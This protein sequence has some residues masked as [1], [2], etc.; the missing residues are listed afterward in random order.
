MNWLPAIDARI[1]QAIIAGGF[2]ALGWV[3][4]GWQNRRMASALRAEKLRDMHRAIYAEIGTHLANLAETGDLEAYAKGLAERIASEPDFVPFIPREANDHVF[5]R[6]LDQISLLPRH[7]IDPI[8]QYY[9]QIRAISALAEDM[10]GE[11]YANMPPERRTE[12]YR[13]YIEMK[14]QALLFGEYALALI[15]AYSSGGAT[16]ARAEAARLN[17]RAWGPSVQ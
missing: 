10:R 9:S 11:R 8:V 14:K 13:D 6:L 17:T 15:T 7:T 1:W 12:I 5:D 2:L 4:N 16:A 3:F